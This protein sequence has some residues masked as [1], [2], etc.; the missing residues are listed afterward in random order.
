[1]P[2]HKYQQDES[3]YNL[4][5]KPAVAPAPPQKYDSKF[6]TEV[7]DE[8]KRIKQ[9]HRTMG[10]AKE[11]LAKPSEYLKA[12]EKEPRLPE[13]QQHQHVGPKKPS[14]PDPVK[15]KPLLGI[16][17]N[18]NFISQNAVDTIMTVPKKPENNVVDTRHG[19][20]FPL[21]PSGLAPVYIKKK[22]FGNTPSYIVQRK[23]QSEKAKEEYDAYMAEYFKKGAL[24]TMNESERD[25]ILEGLKL[26]WDELHHKFQSLSVITDTIPKRIKKEKLETEMKLLEK[27]I[28][29]LQRHQLIYI[30]D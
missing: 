11:P 23:E 18:K 5:P 13:P 27:D 14:V 20:K 4:I 10:Y 25:A 22:D 24:R 1:M 26:N 30:A 2:S 28:D 15:D 7:R 12:H 9:D 16:K 21:Y 17:T 6:K 3:I 29:L 8:I 19:S